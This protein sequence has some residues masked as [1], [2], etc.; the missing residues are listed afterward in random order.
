MQN[1]RGT[2]PG[3]EGCRPRCSVTSCGASPGRLSTALG[4]CVLICKTR[5]ES[6]AT[7]DL[8]VQF[9][10]QVPSIWR[11]HLGVEPIMPHTSFLPPAPRL[12]SPLSLDLKC[13]LAWRAWVAQ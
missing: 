12:R 3:W 4:L 13:P 10:Y 8:A 11:L 7:G 1:E 9:S 5:S 2:G 6:R